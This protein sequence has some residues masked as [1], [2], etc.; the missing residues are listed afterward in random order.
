MRKEDQTEA[1]FVKKLME[2]VF[3][4]PVMR[5]FDIEGEEEK[6][7]KTIMNYLKKLPTD[8]ATSIIQTITQKIAEQK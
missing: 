8:K 6:I 7:C 5:M 3:D 4:N 1:D 2:E